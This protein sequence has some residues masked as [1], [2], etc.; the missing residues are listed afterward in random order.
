MS[1]ESVRVRLVGDCCDFGGEVRVLRI[2][3]HGGRCV[4]RDVIFGDM[5][6][7]VVF[8]LDVVGFLVEGDGVDRSGVC[9][10]FGRDT[11]DESVWVSFGFFVFR[12]RVL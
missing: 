10:G 12:V 9:V 1:D 2:G 6:C 5:M 11:C 4:V 7:F 3:E 8:G